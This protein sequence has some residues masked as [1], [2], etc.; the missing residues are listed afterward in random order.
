MFKSLW[1]SVTE[2]LKIGRLI[3]EA[4]VVG[5]MTVAGGLV[6]ALF[7][8]YAA[9]KIIELFGTYR[10][11]GIGGTIWTVWEKARRP[12][13]VYVLMFIGPILASVMTGMATGKALS[14]LNSMQ[15]SV[16]NALARVDEFYSDDATTMAGN[17]AEAVQSIVQGGEGQDLSKGVSD[18][19]DSLQKMAR[20]EAAIKNGQKVVGSNAGKSSDDLKKDILAGV[21]GAYPLYL[22]AR[23]LA[24]NRVSALKRQIDMVNT[25]MTPEH[26][27]AGGRRTSQ[28]VNELNAARTA[29]VNA[30]TAQLDDAQKLRD[31]LKQQG[32]TLAGYSQKYGSAS[33]SGGY[34]IRDALT[35]VDLRGLYEDAVASLKLWYGGFLGLVLML[36]PLLAALSVGINVFKEGFQTCMYIVGFVVMCLVGNAIAAPLA[37]LFMLT[38]LSQTTESYGRSYINFFLS[39]VFASAGLEAMAI[40]AGRSLLALVNVA[41]SLTV[42]DSALATTYLGLLSG[43]LKSA[44]VIFAVGMAASF[45]LGLVKRGAALGSGILSGGFPA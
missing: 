5:T 38:L 27:L 1:D 40:L 4:N 6:M 30:L 14:G 44:A 45:C 7:W 20:D 22:K 13:T 24:M 9:Y 33:Q 12:M 16:G 21:Q 35:I 28:L 8:L 39:M 17:I 37:P 36:F 23:E 29:R 41:F 10:G 31:G 18:V 11:D 25:T 42:L 15:S 32:Q 3:M 43:V 34:S 19:M 2:L 26:L